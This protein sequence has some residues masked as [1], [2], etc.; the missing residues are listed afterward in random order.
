MKAWRSHSEAIVR[1]PICVRRNFPFA[2]Y[3][4]AVRLLI[5]PRN[6]TALHKCEAGLT[7]KRVGRR[8]A[9]ELVGIRT[10]DNPTHSSAPGLLRSG[11]P[12]RSEQGAEE[13]DSP[14]SDIE[15]TLEKECYAWRVLPRDAQ[16]MECADWKQLASKH[17]AAWVSE[18]L[19]PIARASEAR[20]KERQSKW[21]FLNGLCVLVSLPA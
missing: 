10:K 5:P 4:R 21:A 2:S 8:K 16:Q 1:K 14:L 6:A 3:A 13:E 11:G 18:L 20:V 12:L 15:A 17:P 7:S 19:V 9:V